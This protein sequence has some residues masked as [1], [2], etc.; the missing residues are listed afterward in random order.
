MVLAIPLVQ[1]LYSD[2]QAH[3]SIYYSPFRLEG[4][5][6]CSRD[7]V[8]GNHQNKWDAFTQS[9]VIE[10]LSDKP[11]KF[12]EIVLQLKALEVELRALEIELKAREIYEITGIIP[13]LASIIVQYAV[14]D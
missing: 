9:R 13:P 2:I 6:A 1:E 4:R 8:R 10:I 11:S 7:M 14:K 5:I 12:T 3:D